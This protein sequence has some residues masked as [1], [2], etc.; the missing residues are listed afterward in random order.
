M[1]RNVCRERTRTDWTKKLGERVR[2]GETGA[3]S[4]GVHGDAEMEIG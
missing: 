2:R 3:K 4:Q 1:T